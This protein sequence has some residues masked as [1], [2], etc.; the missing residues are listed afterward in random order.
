MNINLIYQDNHRTTERAIY[1]RGNF[2][3]VTPKELNHDSTFEAH[4]Q[5]TP[6]EFRIHVPG[7]LILNA[8]PHFELNLEYRTKFGI[9]F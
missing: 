6:L 4:I 7:D 8:K 3:K 9:E 2:G 1:V 5:D